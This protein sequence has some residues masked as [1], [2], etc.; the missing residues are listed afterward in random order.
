MFK[1]CNT[2][3]CHEQLLNH[4]LSH[5]C[6]CWIYDDKV[7]RYTIHCLSL[8]CIS[9]VL[10]SAIIL[11]LRFGVAIRPGDA[12]RPG[13]AIRRLLFRKNVYPRVNS[14]ENSKATLEAGMVLPIPLPKQARRISNR[15][16]VAHTPVRSC[17]ANRMSDHAPSPDQVR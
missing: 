1:S 17:S 11:N 14:P 3:V 7:H 2:L 16:L 6:G 15:V 12:I 10:R 8:E 9:L 5:V 13:T 4:V